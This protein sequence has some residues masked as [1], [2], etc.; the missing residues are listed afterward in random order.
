MT[1]SKFF[2]IIYLQDENNK[3]YKKGEIKMSD[4]IKEEKKTKVTYFQEIAELVA[5]SDAENKDELVTFVEGQIEKLTNAAQKAAERRAKKAE[6][7]DEILTA[8]ENAI[9]TEP[10]TAQQIADEIGGEVTKAK[11][12]ARITKLGDKV[13]KQVTK[14]ENGKVTVYTKA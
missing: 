3:Q 1:K 7:P 12:V 14:T 6:E 9:T 2:D 4:V 5:A 10:K 8:V 13:V 11:V